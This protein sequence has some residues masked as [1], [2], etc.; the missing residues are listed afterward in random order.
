[1]HPRTRGLI[2]KALEAQERADAFLK[3]A[4]GNPYHDAKGRFASG[5][6]GGGSAPKP[7]RVLPKVLKPV[8]LVHTMRTE[9]TPQDVAREAGFTEPAL[10]NDSAKMRRLL[11]IATR[12]ESTLRR[13]DRAG[14]RLAPVGHKPTSNR[15]FRALAAYRRLASDRLIELEES[16]R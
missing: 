3:T 12:R 6:G 11:D 2:E 15:E 4:G 13:M 14:N 5:P 16:G 10:V 8:G 9:W 7:K 1:M